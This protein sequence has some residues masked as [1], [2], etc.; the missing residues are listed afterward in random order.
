MLLVRQSIV[1]DRNSMSNRS[2]MH[3]STSSSPSVSSIQDASSDTLSTVSSPSSFPNTGESSRAVNSRSIAHRPAF[4]HAA[5]DTTK[6]AKLSLGS[7]AGADAGAGAGA[8]AGASASSGRTVDMGHGTVA[9]SY[10][11]ED[12]A[13]PP[14][15]RHHSDR[16]WDS[17]SMRSSTSY[18]SKLDNPYVSHPLSYPAEKYAHSPPPRYSPPNH[19]VNYPSGYPSSNASS[20]TGQTQLLPPAD[21]TSGGFFSCAKR[22]LM[23]KEG[24]MGMA[25]MLGWV[26]TT[27]GFLVA[28]AF[29]RGELFGGEFSAIWQEMCAL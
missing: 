10:W 1:F 13:Q 22:K 9:E 6:G 20:R 18:T 21:I 25:L 24:G 28:T 27:V 2:K 12:T 19:A 15:Y 16:R 29:W 14:L 26:I 7:V 8:G 4:H 3:A 11:S 5:T 23:G 17:G